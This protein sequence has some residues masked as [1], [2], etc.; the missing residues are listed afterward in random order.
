MLIVEYFKR[1]RSTRAESPNAIYAIN[2]TKF[3]FLY[4]R[5]R[6]THT[7]LYWNSHVSFIS[8]LPFYQTHSLEGHWAPGQVLFCFVFFRLHVPKG[9]R[10][11]LTEFN[12]PNHNHTILCLYNGQVSSP[13]RLQCRLIQSLGVLTPPQLKQNEN[14]DIF[15]FLVGAVSERTI[16]DD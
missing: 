6:S 8:L 2:L 13:T 16:S 1:M 15:L 3:L 11:I 12:L 10:Q 9:S 7:A 5:I 4:S 14:R